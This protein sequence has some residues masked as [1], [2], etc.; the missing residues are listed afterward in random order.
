MTHPPPD[1]Q[2]QPSLPFPDAVLQPPAPMPWEQPRQPTDP[3]AFQPPA[4]RRSSTA[5]TSPRTRTRPTWA[6]AGST[7]PTP[8]PHKAPGPAPTPSWPPERVPSKPRNW[9]ILGII[10]TLVICGGTIATGFGRGPVFDDEEPVTLAPTAIPRRPISRTPAVAL[11]APTAIVDGG[12]KTSFDLLVGTG[13]RFSDKDGTW[14]VALLG[15]EW[16]DECEDILGSAVPVVVF[17]IRYEVIEGG[18][19]II[20]LNDFALVLANGTTARVGLLPTCAEP[21]LDY[22]IISAGDVRR[23]QITVELPSSAEGMSGELTYG[24]LGVPTASWT[25]P[26]PAR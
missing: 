9:L 25:I 4:P 1:P 22:T 23:G 10:A 6:A 3:P 16:F 18:V 7:A 13:V 24:Q 26:E 8:T 5:R 11:S 17:D 12:P 19:S 15:V 20:P 21:P 14:T 2:P